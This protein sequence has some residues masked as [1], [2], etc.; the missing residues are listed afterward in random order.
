MPTRT[1]G[2]LVRPI[3]WERIHH[4]YDTIMR[5]AHSPTAGDRGRQTISNGLP[6]QLSA[7]T[8]RAIVGWGRP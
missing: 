5:Y 7:S 4:Q 8:Y 6:G 1:S 3:R 2:N